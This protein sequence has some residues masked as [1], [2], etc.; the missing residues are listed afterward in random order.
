MTEFILIKTDESEKVKKFL[1]QENINYEICQ[2]PYKQ[3]SEAELEQA[4][5]E[6]WSNPQ[7]YKEAQKW[8]RAAVS[9]WAKRVKKEKK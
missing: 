1:Q 9:D 5:R 6:A 4:Y 2:E 8:E 7:R 3:I